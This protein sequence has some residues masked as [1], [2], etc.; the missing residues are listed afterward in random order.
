MTADHKHRVED[1]HELLLQALTHRQTSNRQ[2][3]LSSGLEKDLY[4][5]F[6][7]LTD[8][9]PRYDLTHSLFRRLMSPSVLNAQWSGLV[10]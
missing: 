5:I 6:G 2:L 10:W 7:F 9:S 3:A 4:K 8:L 1:A